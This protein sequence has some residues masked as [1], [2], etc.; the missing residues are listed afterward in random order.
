MAP[1][2]T[3]NAQPPH[4]VSKAAKPATPTRKRTS[5]RVSLTG[6]GSVALDAINE[7]P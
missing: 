7:A 6:V 5:E 3:G 4:Q 2:T 1:I